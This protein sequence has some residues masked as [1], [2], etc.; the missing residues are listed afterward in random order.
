[1]SSQFSFTEQVLAVEHDRQRLFT[2]N[3]LKRKFEAAGVNGLASGE[4]HEMCAEQ[5]YNLQSEVR[6]FE[7]ELGLVS[8]Q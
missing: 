7:N 6:Q 8:L 1:M 4:D 3:C 5:G 2:S